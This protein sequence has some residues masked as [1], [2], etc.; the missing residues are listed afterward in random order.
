MKQEVT[1]ESGIRESPPYSGRLNWLA[2][3]I[4]KQLGELEGLRWGCARQMKVMDKD[5]DAHF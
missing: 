1:P 2:G 4:P 3:R 5:A